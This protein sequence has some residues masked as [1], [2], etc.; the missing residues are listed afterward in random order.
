MSP[1]TAAAA[2]TERHPDAWATHNFDRLDLGSGSENG[3]KPP[4]L[5]RRRLE[6][7]TAP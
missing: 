2:K 5:L 1:S 3:R 6:A 4:G 7:P